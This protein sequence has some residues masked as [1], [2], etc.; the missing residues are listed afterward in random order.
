MASD[1]DS[2]FSDPDDLL[3]ALPAYQRQSV[4]TL[5][6]SGKSPEEVA[7]LWLTTPGPSNTFPFGGER[8][9]S[10]FY[11][12]LLDELEKFIC[13][14]KEYLAERRELISKVEAGKVVATSFMTTVI[15]THLGTTP[16]LLTPAVVL[17]LISVSRIGRRAWCEARAEVRK[18]SQDPSKPL[19]PAEKA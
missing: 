11:D 5:L 7:Q 2:L 18:A 3:D 1:L 13:D 16:A 17:I 4:D 10:V 6:N 9:A 8:F 19:P 12:K 15:A 14:D